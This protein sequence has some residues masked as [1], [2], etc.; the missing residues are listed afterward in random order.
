M[1]VC[2]CVIGFGDRPLTS[3][4]ISIPVNLKSGFNTNYFVT[5]SSRATPQS[6]SH[7]KHTLTIVC[8]V[9]E[10]ILYYYFYFL[11]LRN[12]KKTNTLTRS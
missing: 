12:D 3:P 2:V 11:S 10:F 4:S 7:K 5:S 9:Q 1:G 8:D 6:H